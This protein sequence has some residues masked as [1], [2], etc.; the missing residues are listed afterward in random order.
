MKRWLP[1][2]AALAVAFMVQAGLVGW[3]VAD[4]ALLLKNGHEVRLAVV[5][6]DP[7]DLLRGDYVVLSYDISRLDSDKL[8]G[9]DVFAVGDPIYVTLTETGDASAITHAKPA[10]RTWIKGKVGTI[11]TRDAACGAA[12]QTYV[13]DYDIEKFFVPEGTGHELEQLRNGQHL[14]VDVA[15]GADGRAALKRLLVDGATRYEVPLL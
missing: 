7:R 12:C 4:R 6:V 5:P 2:G 13:V 14:A 11:L 1:Y 10:D 9:D 3:L 8:A 15:V